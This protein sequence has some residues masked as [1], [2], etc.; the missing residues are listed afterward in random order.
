M[1]SIYTS[2]RRHIYNAIE[3]LERVAEQL[4]PD[5]L[6]YQQVRLAL[7]NLYRGQYLNEEQLKAMYRYGF[8]DGETLDWLDDD[9]V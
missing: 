9:F 3:I 2:G 7:S 1:K 5:T 8:R 6:R 4:D